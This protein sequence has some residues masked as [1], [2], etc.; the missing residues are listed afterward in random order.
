VSGEA[1]FL[2]IKACPSSSYSSNSASLAVLRYEA[3]EIGTRL[4]EIAG[5]LK[6]KHR[7]QFDP[8]TPLEH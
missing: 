3:V 1:A 6:V 2:V 8:L 4:S 5:S 7:R